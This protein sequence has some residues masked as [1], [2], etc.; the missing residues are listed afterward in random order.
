MRPADGGIPRLAS[1]VPAAL[2]LHLAV[3]TAA[4]SLCRRNVFELNH[5]PVL[6]MEFVAQAVE[7]AQRKQPRML[8]GRHTLPGPTVRTGGKPRE[9]VPGPANGTARPARALEMETG[10]IPLPPASS[11]ASHPAS[12]PAIT[13]NSAVGKLPVTGVQGNS[14]SSSAAGTDRADQS[15]RGGITGSVARSGTD[16][17][18]SR[19][20]KAYAALLQRLI[21]AH[22]EYPF[23]SRRSR[24]EGSCRRRFTLDR[25][26]RLMLV[27]AL[28]SCNY[29]FLDESATRAITSV[30]AFPPLP[31]TLAG[32]DASFT[33]TITFTLTKP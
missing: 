12:S 3:V 1:F 5:P 11:T 18:T 22:R 4:V 15:G 10:S 33:F 32:E 6:T 17:E 2:L 24:Q 31:D 29:P 28:S 27:E 14:R 30:G 25:N 16:E 8:N 23:A 13:R 21:E 26:G 9:I 19:G 7:T 20:Y